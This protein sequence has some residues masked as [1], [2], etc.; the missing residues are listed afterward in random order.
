MDWTNKKL[1]DHL[2]Q[3]LYCLNWSFPITKFLLKFPTACR[4]LFVI[5]SIILK[6][7]F[8]KFF[9]NRDHY[10]FCHKNGGEICF[11]IFDAP[12]IHVVFAI[13]FILVGN[14]RNQERGLTLKSNAQKPFHPKLD[15]G[16]WQNWWPTYWDVF[17]E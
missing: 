9:T 17:D 11:F 1:S 2:Y 13:I 4:K 7:S 14:E 3:F 10:L 12:D 5:S 6:N 8:W 16:K 15:E